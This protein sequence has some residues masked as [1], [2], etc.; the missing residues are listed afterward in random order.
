MVFTHVF[1]HG[2]AENV[3]NGSGMLVTTM[4]RTAMLYYLPSA[5]ELPLKRSFLHDKLCNAIIFNFI[6]FTQNFWL[7]YNLSFFILTYI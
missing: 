2:H 4:L 5:A 1:C 3:L 6:L 7:Y